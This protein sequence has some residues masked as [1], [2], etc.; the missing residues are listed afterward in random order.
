MD[1]VKRKDRILKYSG[2]IVDVYDDIME[3]PDGSI[4]HWD[5]IEHRNGAAAV[6]PGF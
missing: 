3:I 6:L 2:A 5:Y 4:A 1:R